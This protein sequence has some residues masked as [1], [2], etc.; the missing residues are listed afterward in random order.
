M[1]DSGHLAGE[2]TATDWDSLSCYVHI[3]LRSLCKF[4]SPQID[5]IRESM[6]F[7]QIDIKT[8]LLN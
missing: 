3:S 5:Q 4:F 7:A 2:T 6:L 8:R 1:V